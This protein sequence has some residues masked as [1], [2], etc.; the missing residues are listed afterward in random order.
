MPM[1]ICSFCGV[2]FGG[3]SPQDAWDKVKKHEDKEHQYELQ[4]LEAQAHD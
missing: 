1:I 3:L 4:E 2:C